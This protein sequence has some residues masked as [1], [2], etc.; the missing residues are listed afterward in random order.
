MAAVKLLEAAGF[1]V[2]I[3]ERR[4]CCGRPMLSKGLVNDARARSQRRTLVLLTHGTASRSLEPNRAACSPSVTST[5]I[6]CQTTRTRNRF[7]ILVMI[8]ELAKLESEGELGITWSTDKPEVF[9]HGHCHQKALVIGFDVDSEIGRMQRPAKVALVVAEWRG[10]SATK[11]NTM[12]SPARSVKSVSSRHV[13]TKA[14]T[15]IAVRSPAASR[16]NTSPVAK[17]SI[18]QRYW[19]DG[20]R[21]AT[22]GSQSGGKPSG[23]NPDRTSRSET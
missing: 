19:R 4:A 23:H 16:S 21:R 15:A 3:E 17:R 9:F 22:S 12:K 13:S 20:S 6:S 10:H 5:S 18:L 7:L 1:E 14:D 11:L 8:D 2:V